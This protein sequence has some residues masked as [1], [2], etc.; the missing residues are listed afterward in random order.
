MNQFIDDQIEKWINTLNSQTDRE[1]PVKDF[2]EGN[3][4]AY[5]EIKSFIT[6]QEKVDER[7]RS[8][9]EK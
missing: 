2:A 1:T 3:L 4:R 8:T 6:Q 7:K 5:A 9:K